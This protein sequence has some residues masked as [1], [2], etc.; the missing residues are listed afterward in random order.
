MAKGIEDTT[1]YRHVDI[2]ACNEVGDSP[3]PDHKL[4]IADFMLT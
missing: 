2:L 4:S 3:A 1:F